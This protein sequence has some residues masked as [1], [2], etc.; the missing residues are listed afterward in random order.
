MLNIH[1]PQC[2]SKEIAVTVSRTLGQSKDIDSAYCHACGW[3]GY[4]TTIF[5]P[6]QNTKLREQ[7]KIPTVKEMVT[8]YLKSHGFDGLVQAY[9][10]SC[11]C[12]VDDLAPCGTIYE[13]CQA[14]YLV[15]C[16]CEDGCDF[17]ISTVKTRV[18]KG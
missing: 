12:I 16:D 2:K 6:T 9:D 17:H 3:V 5:N 15:S 7:M 14:G 1:C 4:A 10:A 8:A 18:E 13:D 11:S